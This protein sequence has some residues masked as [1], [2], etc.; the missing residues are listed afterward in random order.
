M[1]LYV[2]VFAAS[3]WRYP[4]YFQTPLRW[5]PV[6]LLYTLLTETLGMVIR[7]NPDFSIVFREAYYNNNWVIFNIYSLLFFPYFLLVFHRYLKGKEARALLR[8]GGLA[9]G[10]AFLLNAVFDD[11]Q[12]QSQVYAYAVGALVLMVGALAYLRQEV[13]AG[14]PVPVHRNLLVWVSAGIFLFC[15]GYTPIK[16]L[17]Y[18][19]ANGYSDYYPT[20]IRPLHFGLIYVLYGCF[21]LGFL[22]MR[23]LKAPHE[24]PGEP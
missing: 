16:Y 7:I 9:Y 12:T 23:P 1:L 2:V 4:A 5:L 18:L 19:V 11:F 8:Y 17:K 3:L 24:S 13:R 15:L 10:V 22:W 20:W 21:L 6:L 14:V